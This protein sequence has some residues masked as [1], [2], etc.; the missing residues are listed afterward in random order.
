MFDKRLMLFLHRQTLIMALYRLCEHNLRHSEASLPR[1]F[2]K[3]AI[4]MLATMA[5]LSAGNVIH[6]PG[7]QPTIQ[8]GIAAAANGDTV[9]VMAGTY[10]EN[11][12]FNGKAIIVTSEQGAGLT[13]I[14]GQSR[15][16]VATFA[17]SEGLNS[18]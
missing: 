6:V 13:V 4:L 1:R 12:N 10:Y 11:I 14:D 8:A 3:A 18:I 15:G 16:S 7:D 2:T 9:L 5:S 17:T